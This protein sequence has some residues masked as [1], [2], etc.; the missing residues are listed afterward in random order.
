MPI[1]E[2]SAAKGYTENWSAGIANE[3]SARLNY[4]RVS[5]AGNMMDV[6]LA[7]T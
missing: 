5:A 7:G 3:A 2:S 4:P 1:P 6:I